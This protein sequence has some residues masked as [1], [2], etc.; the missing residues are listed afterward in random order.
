MA[1]IKT[2]GTVRWVA[3]GKQK[4]LYHGTIAHLSLSLLMLA[5][6]LL[7]ASNRTH[8]RTSLFELSQ[9]LARNSLLSLGWEGRGKERMKGKKTKG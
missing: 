4:V 7:I 2:T 3:R 9:K 6:V 1:T 5:V 8:I